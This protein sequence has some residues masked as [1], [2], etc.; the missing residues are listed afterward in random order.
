MVLEE[1]ITGKTCVNKV[2]SMQLAYV[3]E[4]L[5]HCRYN[6]LNYNNGQCAKYKPVEAYQI[7][8]KGMKEYYARPYV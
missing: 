8:I 6:C 1:R 5:E 7:R 2:L 4:E 3:P